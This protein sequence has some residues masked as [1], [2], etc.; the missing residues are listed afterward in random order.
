MQF[1][2]V[3]GDRFYC[4]E[5]E[6]LFTGL[7]VGS[8]LNLEHFMLGIP[9]P[10]KQIRESFCEIFGKK[11]SEQFFD[12]F[13]Y[14]FLGEEDFQFLRDTGINLIRVPFHYGLF[15]DDKEPEK[16]RE[17]GFEYFDRILK[18]CTKY[19]IYLLPD[20]HSVPGGQNPD[21]HSDNQ[22]GT[23]QFWHYG[24]FQEHAVKLWKAIAARYKGEPYLLGYDLLNEPYLMPA[25]KGRIQ[26]FYE[27]VTAAVREVDQNHILFLEGDHFAMDFSAI[28][29]LKDEQTAVTFH[30]YPT[31]WES[32]LCD[33]NYPRE[34]RREI[35]E[36]RF[37]KMIVGMTRFG[38]PLL[39]GE[40]GYD[41][42]GNNLQHVMEMVEDTLD[43]FAKYKVS[44]TLWCYKD[45]GFMGIAY[46][47]AHSLWM[48]F[49]DEIHKYWTHYLEMDMGRKIVEE[50]SDMFPGEVSE[51]LKYQLQFRQ[52]ALL[53]TL[54]KE[55][56]LKPQLK[57]WGWE[58]VRKMPESF[59]FKNGNYYKEY[60]ELLKKYTYAMQRI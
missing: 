3:K 38:R 55:Q 54:Q 21:W 27:K 41:I 39:C 45:A 5:K 6:M 23:P 30:F 18:F 44:W 57:R 35:F 24:V 52:R 16:L 8:W 11:N 47:D 42:A 13:V 17:K 51:E 59:L 2:K 26:K 4:G 15:I 1:V 46:P 36:D 34:K 19:E 40:A 7:G 22:T 48:E 37:K 20:L 25:E 60:Q 58:K 10:E 31:V 43:L 49:A 12:E 9:T 32:E 33:I 56:I 53:F 29:E 28:E 14:D 50:M